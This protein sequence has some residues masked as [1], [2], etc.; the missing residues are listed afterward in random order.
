MTGIRTTHDG[1]TGTPIE[2]KPILK[3]WIV[4]GP[5]SSGASMVL[6]EMPKKLPKRGIVTSIKNFT[7]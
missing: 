4:A 1:I 3:M 7:G 2:T 5:E 6:A